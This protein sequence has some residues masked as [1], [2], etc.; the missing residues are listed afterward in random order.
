MQFHLKILFEPSYG[1]NCLTNFW[2][3]RKLNIEFV[4]RQLDEVN[5]VSEQV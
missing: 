3:L 4:K 2:V 1:T 5:A